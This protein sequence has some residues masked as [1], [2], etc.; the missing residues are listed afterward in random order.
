MLYFLQTLNPTAIYRNLEKGGVMSE[1]TQKMAQGSN[2]PAQ[3]IPVYCPTGVEM[4][5]K[6]TKFAPRINT[7][8]GKR[9]GLMWN[10][11]PNGDFYLKR[12]AELLSRK[13]PDAKIIKFREVD[14]ARTAHA[15]RKTPDALDFM[16]SQTDAIIASTA[17]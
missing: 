12:V 9:I 8:S 11:K 16:A 13:Y 2:S 17:D 3:K 10:C 1:E 6:A 7:F 5:E 14:P 4:V 15:D